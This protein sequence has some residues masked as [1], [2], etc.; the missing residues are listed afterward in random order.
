MDVT[1]AETSKALKGT[2]S[3]KALGPDGYQAL[4]FKRTWSL[5]GLSVLHFAQDLLKE[6]EIPVEVAKALS[7]L[8]P[9]EVKPSSLISSR[10]ISLCN[11]PK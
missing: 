4:F 1:L 3:L 10:P 11:V 6:A 7:V 5:T 8:I 9:K 2:R